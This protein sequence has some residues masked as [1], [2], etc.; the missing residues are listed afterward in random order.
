MRP[1]NPLTQ[2]SPSDRTKRTVG[3]GSRLGSGSG[4]SGGSDGGS[5][6][7]IGTINDVR[8]RMSRSYPVNV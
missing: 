2:T 1:L 5:G 7:R 8:G 6:R 4:G 3:G